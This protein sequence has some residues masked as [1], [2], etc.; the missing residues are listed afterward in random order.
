M[1]PSRCQHRQKSLKNVTFI[2][3]HCR[4]LTFLKTFLVRSTRPVLHTQLRDTAWEKG[5]NAAKEDRRKRDLIKGGL[6]PVS[7]FLNKKA[8]L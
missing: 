2:W 3:K 4:T 6:D 7:I 8:D 1:L 5:I